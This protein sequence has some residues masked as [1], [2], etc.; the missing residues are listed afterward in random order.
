MT[1]WSTT[2]VLTSLEFVS[3]SDNMDQLTDCLSF[4]TRHNKNDFI[5]LFIYLKIN[6]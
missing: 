3:F 2:N 1:I 5:Y 6:I 4:S